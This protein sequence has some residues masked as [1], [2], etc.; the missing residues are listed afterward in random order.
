MKRKSSDFVSLIHDL[1]NKSTLQCLE[2]IHLCQSVCFCS[3]THMTADQHFKR[4]NGDLVFYKVMHADW[5]FILDVTFPFNQRRRIWGRSAPRFEM[6]RLFSADGKH[7]I[8]SQ[9]RTD[10]TVCPPTHSCVHTSGLMPR[11]QSFCDS[12]PPFFSTWR[13]KF[14]RLNKDLTPC[15]S[16][17]LLAGSGTIQERKHMILIS[18]QIII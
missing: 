15:Q 2:Y 6:Y 3:S 16:I 7:H 13:P 12:T 9:R 1:N 17:H 8:K 4:H 14:I 18:T 11:Y 10:N 5:L